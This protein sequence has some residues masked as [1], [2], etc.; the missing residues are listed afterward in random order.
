MGWRCFGESAASALAATATASLF[1][2]LRFTSVPHFAAISLATCCTYRS[3]RFAI[4]FCLSLR[5]YSPQFCFLLSIL[6]TPLSMAICNFKA[7]H[8]RNSPIT[9]TSYSHSLSLLPSQPL[10][11]PTKC[12]VYYISW[13]GPHTPEHTHTQNTHCRQ[14]CIAHFGDTLHNA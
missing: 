14:F 8:K 6:S 7:T 2:I 9:I 10:S 11:L 3:L 13:N 12:K 5:F 4:I 1:Q